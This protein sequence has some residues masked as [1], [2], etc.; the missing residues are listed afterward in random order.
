M[1]S[2]GVV[3]ARVINF[4]Q[5]KLENHVA[6]AIQLAWK[7]S[8]G[9]PID[10]SHLLKG[11]I[12][13]G[14]SGRSVGFEKLGSLLRVPET[15]VPEYAGPPA[16]TSALPVVTPVAKSFSVAEPFLLDQSSVWGRDFVT[17]ALLCNDAT[18]AELANKSDTDLS[19]VRNEWLDYLTQ[20]DTH[21]TSEEW[22]KWYRAAGVATT[23]DTPQDASAAYLL[24]W[25][26]GPAHYPFPELEKRVSELQEK[27]STEFGWSTGNRRS[28]DQGARVF[29][30]R[31]GVEPRG[32]VGV[33][34]VIGEV[35]ERDHWK[36]E[37]AAAGKKSL[38]VEVRWTALS[39][40]PFLSLSRLIEIS[41][42]KQLWSRQS[43]GT[44]IP[45]DVWARLEESWPG[46]WARHQKGLDEDYLP[47]LE[48]RNL[49][50]NFNA[51]REE[52]DEAVDSLY[53]D[54]Y[55]NAFAR[56]MAS[57]SLTPPL[58]VGLFGD[59]GSGK[60]FFMDRLRDK[61][62]MLA[63][64]PA[65]ERPLY[66]QRI[67]QIKF[68]AWH[69]AETNLWASLVSSI[70]NELRAYLDGP[71][72]DSDEF[73]RL[74]NR[75]E[76]AGELRAKAQQRLKTAEEK[77][78]QARDNTL[79][80]ATALNNLPVPPEPTEEQ[81]QKILAKSVTEVTDVNAATI[82]GLLEDAADFSGNKDLLKAAKLVE[83]GQTTVEEANALLVE[84]RSMSSRVLF[85][86]RILATGK[87]HKTVG[88]WIV[89]LA[90]VAIAAT[91]WIANKYLGLSQGWANLWT[92]IGQLL[93]TVGAAV[94]WMRAR[95]SSA[96]PVFDRLDSMQA[97][98]ERQI[99]NAKNA[100]QQ[101]Y[102]EELRGAQ[103][104]ERAAR[105]ALEE[106]QSAEQAAA[107]AEREAKKAVRE[108]TSQ[109]RLGRFIRERASSADYEQHL[110]L[111]A[112]IHRDF[113]R[114]SDLMKKVREG[115]AEPDLPRID[116]IIL[117]IDDLDRCHPPE[118]VVRILEAVHLL[119]FFPLFVVVV[120]VDSRWVSR[121]LYKHYE[122]MLADE[123]MGDEAEGGLQRAPADSQDFLEK[124]FQVPFWLR[125][126]QPDAVKRLI[127]RLISADELE[128]TESPPTVDV[129]ADDDM[130][131]EFPAPKES[132]EMVLAEDPGRAAAK[133]TTAEAE[134]D[135]ES[136]GEPLAAPTE[137][138]KISEAELRF[139]DEVAPLMPRTPR[140]VKRFVN[141][142]RLYKAALSTPA[143]SSF[144]GT[145]ERPGN[146]RA[147]QVLLA[148]VT[149]TPQFAKRVLSAMQD[150][151][152]RE[153]VND[154]EKA[155]EEQGRRRLSQM[156]AE[157]EYDSE[158][159]WRT[160]LEA[161][162]E[163]ARGENDL[164]L[165]ALHEVSPLVIRYSVHHM[166][167]DAPGEAGLG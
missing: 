27:G 63:E 128:P 22:A 35:Q 13:I 106:A 90:L 148:L 11:V 7:L 30:L 117:Y 61:I 89:I 23:F 40:E 5:F 82:K 155:G 108:S 140:S 39:R 149:G 33:G 19:T 137:G 166:V 88:F 115:K 145:P 28:V 107:A 163:F 153:M 42:D 124:I 98:I 154:D 4:S 34:E 86:W 136:V 49:I 16:N 68:N 151:N 54:R 109:A 132:A 161:L 36:P 105:R 85:W 135:E 43:S 111:I 134:A 57:R 6:D 8:E 41:D 50:A 69:Y 65:T 147:V 157:L 97:S 138:L 83:S 96:S 87:L 1:K 125:R 104:N 45:A 48:A 72:E 164:E 10:A 146:F 167:S 47:E 26:P 152:G 158:E 37:K 141:I 100:D 150:T 133:K 162:R 139:M 18:L 62:T 144:L 24:T 112:M 25:N 116:R 32:L 92:L 55:V 12:F 84:T 101:R 44:E 129:D 21:R 130:I 59:W 127:H 74:L 73:N 159:S 20:T 99:E 17:L 165:D 70:F 120:G 66:W 78:I 75:L 103:T 3:S 121:A 29:L 118:R 119:L 122:E 81:L 95:L 38:I 142:Y 64:E 53:I 60:T 113:E 58:S 14:R 102:Q 76:L 51:D 52:V 114:L 15:Q 56:V 9:R 123:S 131:A 46:A 2:K 143:L 93:T 160:T 77:H 110:G 31:Q 91:F 94:A 80:A 67:C 156:V 71:E 79:T 126:M